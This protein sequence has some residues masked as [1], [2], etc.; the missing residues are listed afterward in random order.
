MLI[1]FSTL[2]AVNCTNEESSNQQK[3]NAAIDKAQKWFRD[4]E[5]DGDNLKVFQNL[6]YQWTN[7][8]VKKAKDG[9]EFITV[10]IDGAKKEVN[11][12][13][14]QK[15][16]IYRLGTDSYKVL[17][18]EFYPE[19]QTT[20][21]LDNF[22]GYISV[23]DL[24]KGFVRSAKF[25]NNIIVENGVVEVLNDKQ[26]KFKSFTNK[27]D[28]KN[29]DDENSNGDGGSQPPIPLREVV[30]EN[31][32]KDDS[33]VYVYSP[34]GTDTSGYSSIDYT[35]NP[36]GG[37]SGGSGANN[38]PQTPINPC[39]K[40][41][42]LTA[43]PN[44]IAK[45]EELGKK[46]NLKIE[47][48][49]SQ[50]K[51]GPFTP[52]VALTSTNGADRMQLVPTSDMIGYV[53][54]HLDNYDSGQV[55]PDGDPLIRQPIKMFSPADIG[56]FLQLVK[57]AQNNNIPIDSVYGAMVSSEGTYQLRFTG[58]PNLI[59]MNFNWNADNLTKDYITYMKQGS[60][61]INFL[62]FL[63]DKC[64]IKGVE[65]YK[66]NKDKTSTKKTLDANKK[67]ANTNC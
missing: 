50:S 17:L 37:G 57:N 56:I 41:K 44:F 8:K 27:Q 16:F 64:Y 34:R 1:F 21:D 45:L 46:T 65:L 61:E 38:T 42:T 6:N 67:I 36:S 43:N 47:T 12:N 15:L 26:L 11:E 4:Y 18:Y 20:V 32:Y 5:A 55:N 24:K 9:I 48:G 3:P 2:I 25:A 59:N 31:S 23:W 66:I 60:K 49:Y 13:W 28:K 30:I 40:I 22:N 53:H 19:N 54:S 14:E 7:A 51:N 39:D 62:N 33:Y 58:D 63:N 52:L 29:L 10:P 35:S